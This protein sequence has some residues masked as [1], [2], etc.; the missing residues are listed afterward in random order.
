MEGL[1]LAFSQA[2]QNGLVRGINIGILD[3]NISHLFFADDVIITTNWSA[4]DLNN[5]IRILQVFFL[6]SGLKINIHKS[7]ILDLNISAHDLNNI[8]RIL[9]VFFLASG[10][11]INIHKSSIYGVG[12][13]SD[14]VQVMASNTGCK[15]GLIPFTYLGLPIGSNMSL[16]AN[17]KL[18]IDKFH[19]KLSS[20]KANL[21]SFGGRLTLI[22]AVLGS[23]ASSDKGGLV[24]G[25]LKS[26]NL[27]LL[28]KWIWRFYS[29]LDSLWVNVIKALHGNG[30]GFDST[31]RFNRLFRLEQDKNCLIV[32]RISNGQWSWNCSSITLGIRN[33]T[34]LNNLL[35]EISLLDISVDAGKC[36]WS[37][38]NDGLFKVGD[39]R[40]P[41]DDHALPTLPTKTTWDK[42]L[43]SQRSLVPFAMVTWSL[44]S[45]SFFNAILPWRFGGYMSNVVFLARGD[46]YMMNEFLKLCFTC[47]KEIGQKDIMFYNDRSFCSDDC[48]NKEMKKD[49][50]E[51]LKNRD[52]ARQVMRARKNI[53]PQDA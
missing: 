1:H 33:T 7:S 2:V 25:S 28:H 27:A 19:S 13:S 26:F 11:K 14:E 47:K 20:W 52:K 39:L 40:R 22:K 53:P 10:L 51:D 46:D 42:V 5:I 32:D 49:T 34:F 9:Q 15:T 8:I 41:I 50:E 48:R 30:G 6:A 17:W 31:A 24:I 21:L 23:L 16:I 29:S 18:L 35:A 36:T 12:V 44:I 37:L 45:I 43:K 38:A 4:H 3:L